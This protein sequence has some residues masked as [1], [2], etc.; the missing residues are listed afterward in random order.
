MSSLSNHDLN[1]RHFNP[2]AQDVPL[3]RWLYVLASP[4]SYLLIRLGAQPNVI[5]SASNITAAIALWV[6]GFANE[7]A[8]FG[9]LWLLAL[10]LDTSDGTVARY[11]GVRRYAQSERGKRL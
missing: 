3:L 7:P 2:S 6:F 4:I 10:L 8:L 9:A 11:T 1:H 5:T